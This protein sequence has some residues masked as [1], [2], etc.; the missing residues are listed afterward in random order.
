MNFTACVPGELRYR[1]L[2]GSVVREVCVRVERDTD[3]V[4]L[5]WRVISAFNEAFNNIVEHSY[6]TDDGDVRVTLAVESDRVVLQLSDAGVGYPFE[7]SGA[8][9]APVMESLSE[10]G[11]GLFII[12]QSMTE[13]TY[14]RGQD[15]NHLTMV[16]R[17]A[18]CA[19][20][21][22]ALHGETRC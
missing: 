3:C 17:F 12:R 15:R 4:G 13:V 6:A 16:Q 5:V 2:V 1:D 22:A 20:T 7:T 9:D 19:P 21:M 18:D 10:G 14:E 8:L 11:M